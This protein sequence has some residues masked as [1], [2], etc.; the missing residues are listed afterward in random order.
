MNLP[1]QGNEEETHEEDDYRCTI[2]RK[3]FALRKFPSQDGQYSYTRYTLDCR[4]V[5]PE[6][7]VR[8]ILVYPARH[9]HHYISIRMDK[10]PCNRCTNM[11]PMSHADYRFILP[12]MRVTTGPVGFKLSNLNAMGSGSSRL[13]D[14]HY[15]GKKHDQCHSIHRDRKLKHWRQWERGEKSS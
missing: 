13:I 8:N 10:N 12:T 9:R 2:D 3:Q 14:K 6:S 4:A 15:S 11:P 1:L 7:S 5:T